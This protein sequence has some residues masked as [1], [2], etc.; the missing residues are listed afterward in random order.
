VIA[1]LVE[2]GLLVLSFILLVHSSLLRTI[3]DSILSKESLLST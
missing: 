3:F 2:G 1:V